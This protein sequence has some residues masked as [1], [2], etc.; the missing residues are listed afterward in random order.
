MWSA[1]CFN[2]D[3]ST[4]LSSVNGL[5]WHGLSFACIKSMGRKLA[6]SRVMPNSLPNDKI[7]DWSEL[8]AFADGQIIVS[9]KLKLV[10]A[11]VENIMGKRRKCWSAAFSP[12]STLFSK[13]F[14]YK[15]VKS[16]AC[17][18]SV[19][20]YEAF[21]EKKKGGGLTKFKRR[22]PGQYISPKACR[23]K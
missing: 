15:V 18:E 9:E 7:L 12:F 4:I 2:L 21:F 1:I 10:L 19:K 20:G 8:K 11:R 6:K 5:K 17:V 3:Q 13:S 16:H 23:E 22:V 14:F